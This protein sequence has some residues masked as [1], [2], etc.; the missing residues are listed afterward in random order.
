MI[1]FFIS[2]APLTF[3][4]HFLMHSTTVSFRT[5]AQKKQEF[6]I[7][8]P[9][10]NLNKGKFL[11]DLFDQRQVF[12][13]LKETT[14]FMVEGILAQNGGVFERLLWSEIHQS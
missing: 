1:N 7:A 12:T 13:Y 6:E 10:N 11:T 2:E 14:G 9:Q 5:I 8:L 4:P 3:A